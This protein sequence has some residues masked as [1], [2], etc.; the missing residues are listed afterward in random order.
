MNWFKRVRNRSITK[1]SGHVVYLLPVTWTYAH[2][3]ASRSN[4]SA[5]ALDSRRSYQR[6][7]EGNALTGSSCLA[8]SHLNQAVNV[9]IQRCALEVNTI[10]CKLMDNFVKVSAMSYWPTNSSLQSLSLTPLTML[11]NA[12]FPEASSPTPMK[13]VW[14]DPIFECRARRVL[15]TSFMLVLE[16]LSDPSVSTTTCWEEILQNVARAYAVELLT[17]CMSSGR[18]FRIETSTSAASWVT[19]SIVAAWTAS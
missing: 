18:L 19:F 4:L 8:N 1:K 17:M 3:H 15:V 7:I 13:I 12:D 9:C 14:H 10:R 16:A 5:R 6:L 11:C 2:V